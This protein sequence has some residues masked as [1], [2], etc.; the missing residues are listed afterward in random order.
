MRTPK[1]YVRD[2]GLVHAL[3]NISAY[4]DLLGHPVVGGSWEG[5]VIENLISV[6]KGR[7]LPYY[8]RTAAGAEIDL[9]LEFSGLE[10]WA[11]EIKRSATP[12]LTK[13]FH[14]ACEDIGANR[15]F[16][17]YSGKDSFPMTDAV[18]AVSLADLMRLVL[19]KIGR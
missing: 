1:V 15:K 8:Y 14:L 4:N 11:I 17:V 3:L 5:F 13:G 18:T 19:E 12:T 2:C 6:V 9:V 7:A 10:K 16:V